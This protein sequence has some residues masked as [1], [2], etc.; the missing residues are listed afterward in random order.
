MISLAR[1]LRSKS[2]STFS[3]RVKEENSIKRDDKMSNVELNDIELN[4]KDVRL[5]FNLTWLRDSCHCTK[6]THKFSRQRIFNPKDFRPHKFTVKGIELKDPS[7]V[8]KSLCLNIRGGHDKYISVT[9]GDDHESVYSIDWLQQVNDLFEG[10]LL[11]SKSTT[12]VRVNLPKDDFYSP[13]DENTPKLSLWDVVDLE[14][15]LKPI[16]FEHLLDG[17]DRESKSPTYI[18]QNKIDMMSRDR[19]QALYSLS[20][21][22][23]TIGIAKIVNVPRELYQVLE[24]SKSLAYERPTG[25]GTVFDVKLEPSD[26]INLAYSSLEFDLHTDLPYREISPGIQM[27]HCITDSKEGGLSYFSDGFKAATSLREDEPDLFDT[28]LR[29]P[30]N[31]LVRDPYRNMKF[32]RQKQIISCNPDGNLSEINYSP[33]MLPPLGH[34]SDMKLFYMAIDKFTR[35]LQSRSSKFIVKINPGDLYIFHNRRVLHGRSAYDA[36]LYRRFLQGSFM[37]W[38]EVACLRE[39]LHQYKKI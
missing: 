1:C 37:D 18:N 20:N 33:F 39:K 14:R 28:L 7:E 17:V 38:D 11:T 4:L 2:T 35:L 9:W 13:L 6:C 30:A 24:L 15:E 31:F 25:Y 12:D 21:Q 22:L 34:K 19:F 29:Y 32:R 8:D 5:V 16:D 27:L 23:V 10:P 3:Y 36:S 26:D